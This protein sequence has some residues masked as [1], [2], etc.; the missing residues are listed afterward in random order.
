[1]KA[2]ALLALLLWQAAAGTE[3]PVAKPASHAV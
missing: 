1:M 2:A 3:P